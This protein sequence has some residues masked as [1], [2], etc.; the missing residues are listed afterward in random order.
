MIRVGIGG[1]TYEPWR[2]TFY[3][4]GLPQARE[5]EHASRQVTAIEVNGTFY[6][7]PKPK[8]FQRWAEETPEGFVFSLK[9]PRYAVNRRIL[10]EAKPS[11]DRFMEAGI[12]ELKDKLG[13]ILWQFAPTKRFD[14]ADFG[15]FLDLLPSEVEGRRLRHVVEVRHESFRVPGFVA[16]ARKAKAAIVLADH[17]EHP[18]IAD[19]TSDFVYA[20]LQRAQEDEPTGYEADALARW[21]KRAKTWAGGGAPDDLDPVGGAPPKAKKRDVFLFMI[22]G[23]KVRAPAAAVALIAR[24]G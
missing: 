1:W 18:L 8:D 22:N 14:E 4:K 7:T 20:R 2:G 19:V 11:I 6:R 3:P 5:L 15:N 17:D 24:L 16:L 13:P 21:A 10:A 12:T 9:A 23:A